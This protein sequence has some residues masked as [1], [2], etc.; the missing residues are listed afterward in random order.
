[1]SKVNVLTLP[2]SICTL[3]FCLSWGLKTIDLN[4]AADEQLNVTLDQLNSITK[5]DAPQNVKDLASLAIAIKSYQRD[6]K[7]YPA[8][9]FDEARKKHIYDSFITKKIEPWIDGLTEYYNN[10]LP[11]TYASHAP[12]EPAFIYRSNKA[13]FLLIVRDAKDCAWVANNHTNLLY[14]R[15]PFFG[16]WVK[17]APLH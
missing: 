9:T 4:R 15:C 11:R 1:M 17:S 8:S 6:K 3:L 14:N 2:L 7:E 12:T 10:P 5:S 16:V 13:Y